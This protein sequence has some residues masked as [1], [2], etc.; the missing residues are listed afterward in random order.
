MRMVASN[1]QLKKQKLSRRPE[2]LKS[3]GDKTPVDP[4]SIPPL[5]YEPSYVPPTVSFNGWSPAPESPIMDLPF[6]VSRTSKG[7]QLPV[8]RDIKNGGTNVLTILRRYTGDIQELSS[9]LSKVC[10]GKEIKVRPGRMEVKGDYSKD[11]KQWL[12]GL[13]F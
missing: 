9:E 1:R 6:N 12:V 5:K 2:H 13:G 11:I 3:S 10:K 8:Y 7:L 4:S